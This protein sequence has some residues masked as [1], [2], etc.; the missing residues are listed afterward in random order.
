MNAYFKQKQTLR[1]KKQS[2]QKLFISRTFRA[3]LCAVMVVSSMMY[4]FQ[5]NAVSQK[6]FELSD[7]QRQVIELERET[8]RLDVAISS[9]R[10]MISIQERLADMGLVRADHVEYINPAGTAVARN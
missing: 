10:S 8:Q 5:T 9:H 1:Q 4:L 3:T 7:L 2:L 6:G